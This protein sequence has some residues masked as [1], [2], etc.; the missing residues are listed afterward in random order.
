MG[1]EDVPPSDEDA[2]IERAR[3]G[4]PAAFD[5]L[6]RRYDRLVLRLA[7]GIVKSEE[8]AR[9]IYQETF[10]KAWKGIR[11]FRN[12][13]SF[14]TWIFRIATN[15]CLDHARRRGTARDEPL[16]DLGTSGGWRGERGEA[17]RLVDRSVEGNPVKAVEAG[18]LR[19][20]IGTALADLP[21]RE[22]L[23]F[24]LRHGE[25]L[26]LGAI[27]AI[28]ETSEETTRNCLYRAHQRLR[29]ALRHVQGG[30]GAAAPSRMTE[31]VT[32]GAPLR[33]T[34]GALGGT[35]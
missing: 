27:A 17:G 33:D 19:R 7:L 12:E 11:R 22:R 13:C 16:E 21:P 32:R 25:G 34:P 4:S 1:I 26:R 28:L 10:L 20:L 3:E 29:A 30:A 8:D 2:L 23:V 31:K 24:G 6:V 9:D 35:E 5:E 15:L 14:G 18:E